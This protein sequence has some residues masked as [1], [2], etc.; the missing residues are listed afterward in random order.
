[1]DNGIRTI[2]LRVYSLSGS[3]CKLSIIDTSRN[4][5]YFVL[6]PISRDSHYFREAN[7]PFVGGSFR[8]SG[9]PTEYLAQ[10]DSHGY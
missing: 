6:A 5:R 10:T 9:G 3:S 1:V 7:E 8:L 2:S 4:S